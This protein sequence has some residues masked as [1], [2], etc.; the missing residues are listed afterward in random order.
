MA[1]FD[2]GTITSD[3]G[4]ILLRELEIRNGI[5]HRFAECFTDY[6]DPELIEHTSDELVAQ[7]VFGLALGYE[8]L[9]D[10]DQLR[11]DPLLATAVGQ[12]GPTGRTPARGSRTRAR[13]GPARAP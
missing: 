13:P 12:A 10:H 9:N 8:D 5:V 7:R 3:G 6:R 1:N 4:A 2:G 11:Q